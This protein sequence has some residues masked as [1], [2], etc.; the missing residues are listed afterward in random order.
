MPTTE[1]EPYLDFLRAVSLVV[2]LRHWA[3]T[4]LHWTPTGPQPTN[5]LA[6]FRGLW[7]LTWFLQVLLC[8]RV[9]APGV[10]AASPGSPR[11]YVWHHVKELVAPARVLILSGTP[12]GSCWPKRSAC[13]GSAAR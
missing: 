4:I 11:S 5:P 2:V 12:S 8:R 1:R 13:G 7:V 3:F 10:L 6:Y 9:G